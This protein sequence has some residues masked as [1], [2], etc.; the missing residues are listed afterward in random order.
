MEGLD[1][2]D[3]CRSLK[4]IGRSMLLLMAE[5]RRSPVE[6]GS[7][8]HYLQGFIHPNGGAGFLPSTVVIT[9]AMVKFR[10]QSVGMILI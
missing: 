8:S 6:V 10:P 2:G 7:L 3:D 1:L 5:I 4:I 9:V